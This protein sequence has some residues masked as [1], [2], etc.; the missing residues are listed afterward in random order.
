VIPIYSET[1]IY[2]TKCQP[3]N[4]T[5]SPGSHIDKI[6][7]ALASIFARIKNTHSQPVQKTVIQTKNGSLDFVMPINK[8]FYNIEYNFEIYKRIKYY[9]VLYVT[10]GIPVESIV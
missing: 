1:N 5:I 4:L 8:L 10:F 6:P 7:L 9:I 3:L 2:Q